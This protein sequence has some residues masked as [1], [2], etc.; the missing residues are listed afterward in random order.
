MIAVARVSAESVR[1]VWIVDGIR[2]K[3]QQYGKCVSAKARAW[4]VCVPFPSS[5]SI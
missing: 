4:T 5:K 2:N 3:S 1:L